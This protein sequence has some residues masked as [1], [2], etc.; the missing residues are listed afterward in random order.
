MSKKKA[1]V[2]SEKRFVKRMIKLNT[3]IEKSI[4]DTLK[5]ST[6]SPEYDSK[7]N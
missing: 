4:L 1:V 5:E 7:D 2:V 3:E 6:R